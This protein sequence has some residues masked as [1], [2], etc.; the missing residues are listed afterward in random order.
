MLSWV[1]WVLRVVTYDEVDPR[2]AMFLDLICFGSTMSPEN[3]KLLRRLDK[4]VPDYYGICL[5]DDE[6][7][8]ISQ[9]LLLHIDTKTRDGLERVAG[10]VGVATMPGHSRRGLSTALMKRAHELARERGMRIAILTTQAWGVAH[11]LYTK[12]G[13]STIGTFDRGIKQLTTKPRTTRRVKLR[14]FKLSDA[15]ALDELFQSQTKDSLGFVYRQPNFFAMKVQSH[16]LSGDGIT[17]ATAGGRIV[18]YARVSRRP[19]QIEVRELVAEDDP[20]RLAILNAAGT[21][22]NAKL[23]TVSMLC[24]ARIANFYERLGFRIY[25]PGCGRVMATSTD[26]SL[27]GDDIASLYG[28]NEGRFVINLDTIDTY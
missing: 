25:S 23:L 5:L 8:L 6:G 10:I 7:R 9:V 26:G 14:K 27:S 24:D 21:Q 12:L 20:T 28:V 13:Y 22:F 3:L 16:Q 19:D 17:V 2:E 15:G 18:G 4:R 11:G 1:V